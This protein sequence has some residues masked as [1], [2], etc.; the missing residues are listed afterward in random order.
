MSRAA[1]PAPQPSADSGTETSDAVNDALREALGTP[2]PAPSRPAGPP[3]SQG[4]RDALRVAVES[5]WNVG[6]LSTAAL[7]TTVVVGVSMTPEGK[8]QVP[9]IRLISHSGGT[10]GAARQAFEAARRA[11]IR[12]GAR[13]YDLPSEKYEHWREIEMTFNP[14]RMRNR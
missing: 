12:C 6:S 1:A 8:P 14:E 4:E 9:S 5:C 7:A 2:E 10:E 13:G 3:L 11:I